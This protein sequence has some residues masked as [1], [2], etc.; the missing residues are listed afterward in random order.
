MAIACHAYLSG[1]PHRIHQVRHLFEEVVGR[2]GVVVWD[3][4]RIMDWYLKERSSG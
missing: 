1:M 3:G 4:V 2:E